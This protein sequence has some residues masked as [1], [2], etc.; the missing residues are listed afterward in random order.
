[1]KAILTK[2]LGPT[3]RR[4]S[5]VKASDGDN[6]V[7]LGWR[8]E[9]DSEGNHDA[10]AIALCRKLKWGGTLCRGGLRQSGQDT[11]NVY[12][13]VNADDALDI[14]NGVTG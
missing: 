8:D 4:G 11:G 9:W 13:W 10:A 3:S 1:M 6:A 7:I 12:V 2:Y 5:R 14:A